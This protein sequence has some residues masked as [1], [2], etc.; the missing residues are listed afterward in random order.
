MSLKIKDIF[1]E[2]LQLVW[3]TTCMHS[4]KIRSFLSLN[5]RDISVS[6]KLKENLLQKMLLDFVFG[7]MTNGI[8]YQSRSW[9]LLTVKH[10]HQFEESPLSYTNLPHIH[11]PF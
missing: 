2:K 9:K 3:L 10:G 1:K 5:K 8:A 11:R 6:A 4:L 7:L